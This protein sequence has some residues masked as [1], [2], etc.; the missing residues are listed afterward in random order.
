MSFSITTRYQRTTTRIAVWLS[1]IFGAV[2]TGSMA[3]MISTWFYA[4]DLAG[5]L[6]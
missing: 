2:T 1:V 5:V 4:H 6:S 3:T